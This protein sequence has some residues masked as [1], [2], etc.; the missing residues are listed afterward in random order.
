MVPIQIWMF[1]NGI[2]FTGITP[3]ELP[4]KLNGIL[5]FS[6]KLFIP[7]LIGIL[8][9]ISER[10][11]ILTLLVFAYGVFSSIFAASRGVGVMIIGLPILLAAQDGKKTKALFGLIIIAISFSFATYMRSYTQF[12]DE[13][14][15]PNIDTSNFDL[16]NFFKTYYESNKYELPNI[17]TNA[18]ISTFARIESFESLVQAIQYDPYKVEGGNPIDLVLL[19]F[20]RMSR[21]FDA[22]SHHIQWQGYILPSGWYNGGGLFSDVIIVRNH[23]GFIWMIL[24]A[25]TTALWLHLFN[26]VVIKLTNKYNFKPFVNT[27]MTSL[28]ILLYI[29]NR[30]SYD[31]LYLLG[32]MIFFIL[33]PKIKIYY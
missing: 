9:F 23:D 20:N 3:K 2:G 13:L 33:L 16:I 21:V 15:I 8:Y 18:L 17:L 1:Q 4:F 6:S 7:I 32:L 25:F 28:L 10:A 14:G 26:I 29:T 31:L 24:L 27:L 12:V 11:K 19:S 30:G 22:N 5:Y